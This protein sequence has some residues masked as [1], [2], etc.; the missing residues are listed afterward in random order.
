MKLFLA[1]VLAAVSCAACGAGGSAATG[2][3]TSSPRPASPA[4]LT[5][6]SPA[7][8]EVVRGPTVHLKVRLAVAGRTA[9]AQ[10]G[11]TY[12][13]VYVDGKIVSIEV[14]PPNDGVSEQAVHG[15]KPGRHVLRVEFVGPNH[16][17]YHPRVIAAVTFVAKR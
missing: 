1:A 8:G 12:L 15:L 6:L 5:I 9:T 2:P 11:P 10:A 17:P 3:P 16:L 7:S 13:H 4:R 14:A